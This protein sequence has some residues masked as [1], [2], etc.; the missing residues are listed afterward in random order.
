MEDLHVLPIPARRPGG[1]DLYGKTGGAGSRHPKANGESRLQTQFPQLGEKRPQ[2]GVSAGGTPQA[3][4][5]RAEESFQIPGRLSG[6]HA[7]ARIASVPASHP[8]RTAQ[9]D[10]T[11][12]ELLH[13]LGLRPRRWEVVAPDAS[14]RRV[15][16]V[17]LS[18][19]SVVLMLYP[20]DAA[21]VVGHH[22]AVFRWAWAHALPVPKLLAATAHALVVEDLGARPAR[23]LLA[24]DRTQAQRELIALLAAFQKQRV[25]FA[26]NP[27]FDAALF[28]RELHQF[29]TFAG[30]ADGA[31]EVAAFCQRLAR[32]LA[33]HPYRLCHR[34]F[35]LDNILWHAS[36]LKV[37][38]FQDMRLGPDTYD[39]VSLLRE[40]G[41]SSLLPPSLAEAAARALGW[42]GGWRER[43]LACAAQRGL[44]ALGTF[45][46][47]AQEGRREYLRL[48]PEVA[49]QARAAVEALGGPQQLTACLGHLAGG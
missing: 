46:K 26:L 11:L 31:P 21:A 27:P 5:Q 20:P 14:V 37:V 16:R 13:S 39:A 1:L 44:K 10:P 41:G 42:E 18:S 34:D 3:L 9:P 49:S 43:F 24:S 30:L 4:G 33:S 36:G 6:P 15:Y 7:K 8:P 35:H 17:F 48:V 19:G 32:D 2:L 47:L 12:E 22:A 40:R 23:Q 28:E 45:L 25:S 29:L 38:D